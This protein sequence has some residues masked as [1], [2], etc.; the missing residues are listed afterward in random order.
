[1]T[2]VNIAGQGSANGVFRLSSTGSVIQAQL[3]TVKFGAVTVK[4][5]SIQL[6]LEPASSEK[7]SDATIYGDV[8]FEALETN[9]AVHLYSSAPGVVPKRTEWTVYAELSSSD[10]TLALSKI[11]PKLKG[12]DFDLALKDVVFIAASQDDPD[13]GAVVSGAYQPK[14]G[15]TE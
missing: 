9:V 15:E 1:M 2:N 14:E 12:T 8:Q 13:I 11:A 5:A 6:D 10:N 3:G 7:S 4:S